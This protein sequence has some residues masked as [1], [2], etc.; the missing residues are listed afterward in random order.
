MSSKYTREK[1]APFCDHYGVDLETLER[2]AVRHF[3]QL[4]KDRP[5][6]EL[7]RS[8]ITVQPARP[9]ELLE[10]EDLSDSWKQP[11]RN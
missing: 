5:V 6:I 8:G 9:V 11:E 4:L 2:L 3:A 1:L 10:P 7:S